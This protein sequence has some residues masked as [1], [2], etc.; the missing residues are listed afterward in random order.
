MGDRSTDR[1]EIA[2]LN[3]AYFSKLLRT[4]LDEQKRSVVERLLANEKA[5]LNES[6]GR[7]VR[8]GKSAGE[9]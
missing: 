2:M 8:G 9:P 7:A 5:K 6:I 4:P 1:A 3:I